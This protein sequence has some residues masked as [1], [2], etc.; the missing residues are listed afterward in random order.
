[1]KNFF[2]ILLLFLISQTFALH[3]VDDFRGG[4]FSIKPHDGLYEVDIGI[5]TDYELHLMAFADINNDKSIDLIFATNKNQS[6]FFY[7]WNGDNFELYKDSIVL[8]Q[9]ILS[10][11]P[12][13]IYLIFSGFQFRWQSRF[14]DHNGNFG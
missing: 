4:P 2:L 8:N 13:R 9:R 10:V 14:T 11:A 6:I 7:T 12:C 3:R 5:S 1:M